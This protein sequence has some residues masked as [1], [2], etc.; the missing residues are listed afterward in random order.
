MIIRHNDRMARHPEPLITI[1]LMR[2]A[3]AAMVM[4]YH[5]STGL[6][7]LSPAEGT[8]IIRGASP[9]LTPLAEAMR[10]NWIGV[11]IFFVISGMVIAGS[12]VGTTSGTFFSRRILRLL[13]AALV[14]STLT[15][16][17]LLI[18]GASSPDLLGRWAASA[19]MWPFAPQIDSAYWTLGVE[20][21]FYLAV[22]VW[23]SV[24]RNADPGTFAIIL[25]AGSCAFWV[26]VLAADYT[27]GIGFFER[28]LSLTLLPHGC[29]FALGMLI[30]GAARR[31]LSARDGAAIGA[32]LCVCAVQVARK[33]QANDWL[34]S[35]RSEPAI[36]VAVFLAG[37]AILAATWRL[38][39]RLARL[40]RP[41]V[42]RTIGLA[43]YPLYLL[44]QKVGLTIMSG[45]IGN[46]LRIEAAVAV[47]MI[48]SVAAAWAIAEYIEPVIRRCLRSAM[49]SGVAFRFNR[50]STKPAS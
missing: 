26:A 34:Y 20:L 17:I 9:A 38:Q 7:A 16:A 31:E 14:C 19:S 29:F 37:A 10:F 11:Q 23:L 3:C 33:A 32:A 48:T 44:H 35:I 27:V 50:Q 41:E 4:L 45:L 40:I 47:A 2:F 21:V 13:P 1:D 46:G 39:P 28:G 6:W 49:G 8:A 12:A 24:N 36:A 43:T 22:A 25:L 30:A 42:A 15:A 5:Y 18:A